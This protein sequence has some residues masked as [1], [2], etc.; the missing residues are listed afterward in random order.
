MP[1]T[2]QADRE[3]VLAFKYGELYLVVDDKMYPVHSVQ[4]LIP[5]PIKRHSQMIMEECSMTCAALPHAQ[6][7]AE[8]RCW[9]SLEGPL[10]EKDKTVVQDA[11]DNA[12]GHLIMTPEMNELTCFASCRQYRPP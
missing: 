4:C 8:S 6:D 9:N 11:R 7:Q 2:T 1:Y 5:E 12:L 3:V 10:R